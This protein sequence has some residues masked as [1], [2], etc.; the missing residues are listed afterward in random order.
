MSNLYNLKRGDVDITEIDISGVTGDV[1]FSGA[2]VSAI[3]S[4]V[5][6]NA[7]VNASA[8]IAFSKLAA[9]TSAQIIVGNGSNVPAAVAVTGDVTLTNGGVTAIAA[10]VIVNADVNPAAAIAGSKMATNAQKRIAHGP[11]VN[12][13]NGNGTTNDQVIIRPSVAIT[14][15]AARVVYTTETSGTIAAATV[16]LGTTVNGVDIVAAVALENSKGVGTITSLTLA[17]AAIAANT[18]LIMRHTGIAA[19][20]A[21]E[22]YIEIEYTIND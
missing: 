22:Y 10:G 9:L 14:L 12:V 18:P 2:G 19:T 11:V 1:T 8:A 21:G 5:V 4:G 17:S 3:A 16:Q 6:V 13:D 20:V 7:D 15:T